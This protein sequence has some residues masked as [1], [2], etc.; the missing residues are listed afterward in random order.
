MK[1]RLAR[2][3]KRYYKEKNAIEAAETMDLEKEKERLLSENAV[4]CHALRGRWPVNVC[5][6]RLERAKEDP[7]SDYS[8]CLNCL[9]IRRI[10]RDHKHKIQERG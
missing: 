6:Q 4:Y 3:Q 9:T 5:L 8:M 2:S 7:D 10:V 1:S